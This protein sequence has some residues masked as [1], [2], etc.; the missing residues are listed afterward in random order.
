LGGPPEPGPPRL[1]PIAGPGRLLAFEG[2]DGAGKSTQAARLAA[3]LA[4]AGQKTQLL[5]EPTDGPYGRKV[6]EAARL[7]RNLASELELFVKDRAQDVEQNILPAL[8]EGRTVIVDR[9]ILSNAAYQGALPG[10]DPEAVLLANAQFPW[11]NLTFLLEID[12]EEG[13]SRVAKRAEVE[14]AFENAPYLAKVKAVYDAQI[15]PGLI[16]LDSTRPQEEVFAAIVEAV[17]GV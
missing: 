9:Y 6:R 1:G 4:A 3:W 14:T 5:K 10:G 8:A 11:P 12:P 7:G 15:L 17:K 13:L 16:R 2:L